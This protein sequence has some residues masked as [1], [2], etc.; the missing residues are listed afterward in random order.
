[1]SVQARIHEELQ[2]F[3]DASDHAYD[4]FMTITTG[5]GSTH[6]AKIV[7]GEYVGTGATAF[8]RLAPA[9]PEPVRLANGS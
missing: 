1:M 4:G 7:Y 2:D 6:A 9:L 3:M 5:N 8:G